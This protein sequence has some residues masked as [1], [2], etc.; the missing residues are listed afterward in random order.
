MTQVIPPTLDIQPFDIKELT[1]G[2]INGTG[3]LDVLLKTVTAHL[4][5]Q[6]KKERIRGTEYASA[7]IELYQACM[8]NAVG[9]VISRHKLPFELYNLEQEG[10]LVDAQIRQIDLLLTKIP[11]EIEAI[12]AETNL[13]NK[14]AEEVVEQI[15]VIPHQIALID[16]QAN[17]VLAETM[18]TNKRV[19]QVTQELAKI[20]VEIALLEKQVLQVASQTALTTSQKEQVDLQTT[21]IPKEILLLDKE[22]E[23]NTAV[24]RLTTAQA[25][26]SEKEVTDRLPIEVANLVKQG[27]RLDKEALL[28]EAQ[29]AQVT[30]QTTK[31][32]TEIEYLQAQIVQLSKQN[33]NLEKDYELKQGQLNIQLEELEIAK[34]SLAIRRKELDSLTANIRSTDAQANLYEQK[35]LTEKAQTL[36]NAAEPLSVLGLN[37]QVLEAQRDGFFRDAEQ[38]AAKLYLDSWIIRRQTDEGTQANVDNLL[39]DKNVGKAMDALLRGIDVIPSNT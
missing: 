31:I 39:Q 25:V 12:Q 27:L 30:T 34:A 9:F 32:P 19:D 23:R 13:T 18:L 8:T 38:K 33:L 20:P 14:R 4:E 3:V 1:S 26:V 28:T 11:H 6:F 29:T 37:K 35:V 22:L 16:N 17:Q 10:K 21:K 36:A 2:T 24:I 5:D 7:F 15:T